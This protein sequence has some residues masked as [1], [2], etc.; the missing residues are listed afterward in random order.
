MIE[1]NWLGIEKKLDVKVKVQSE[2]ISATIM[3][4]RKS[5]R[6]ARYA[7]NVLGQKFNRHRYTPLHL[8]HFDRNNVILDFLSAPDY[9]LAIPPLRCLK[10]ETAIANAVID[11]M[12]ENDRI[13]TPKV[14]SQIIPKAK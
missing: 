12:K 13:Y 10:W 2:T 1:K 4:N 9:G 7:Q 14:K 3:Y 8:R 6:P 5:D 11:N